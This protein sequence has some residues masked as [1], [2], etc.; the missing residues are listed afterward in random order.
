M[1]II[2]IIQYNIY[3]IYIY[4][5]KNILYDFGESFIQITIK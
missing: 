2:I 3:C 4:I 5:F 1:T